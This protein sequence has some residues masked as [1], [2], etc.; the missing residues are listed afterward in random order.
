MSKDFRSRLLEEHPQL[1]ELAVAY[2]ELGV[3]EP[4]LWARSELE[5]SPVLAL[6]LLRAGMLR[7]VCSRDDH[8]WIEQ[9]EREDCS[10]SNPV[11]IKEAQESLRNLRRSGVELTSLTPIVRFVQSVAI[12]N[13]ADLLDAGPRLLPEHSTSPARDS[14]WSLHVVRVDGST[15]PMPGGIS[16]ALRD[17]DEL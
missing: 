1:Q 14:R 10:I 7:E 11:T 2:Q 3:L 12:K 16:A 5:G 8:D 15:V 6:C 17:P 9:I 4:L 13:V